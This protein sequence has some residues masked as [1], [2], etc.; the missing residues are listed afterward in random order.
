MSVVERL[1]HWR[2]ESI[3]LFNLLP[4]FSSLGIQGPASYISFGNFVSVIMVHAYFVWVLVLSFSLLYKS[5]SYSTICTCNTC[6]LCTCIHNYYFHYVYALVHNQCTCMLP[7]G[8]NFGKYTRASDVWSYSI[9]LW[10]V[11]SCGLEPYSGMSNQE[12]RRQVWV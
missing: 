11:F 8:F 4:Q 12:A 7:Q 1:G 5:I 10:E 6:A 9:L 3:R 2:V